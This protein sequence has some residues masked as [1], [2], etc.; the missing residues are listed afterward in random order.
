MG[1]PIDRT[2][3][4]YGRLTAVR[5]VEND[6]HGNAQWECLCNCGAVVI[7]DSCRL[8][9]GNT[10]SCGCLSRELSSA[11]LTE[12]STTH[13]LSNTRTYK[14]WAGMRKRCRNP[15]DIAYCYYGGRGIKVCERWMKFENF[16]ADMGEV[17]EG[18]SIERLDVNGDYCPENCVWLP[19]SEQRKNV[20]NNVHVVY[21]GE[22]MI[23]ADFARKIGRHPSRVSGWLKKGFTPEQMLTKR[24]RKP[25]EEA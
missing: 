21:E 5:R 18:M 16:L 10:N 12:R 6:K 3:R 23:L 11:R 19:N 2:G 24:R 22:K 4:K 8:A 20:R 1:T 14:V 9:T 13:G 25:K 7:V 17:P 15:N